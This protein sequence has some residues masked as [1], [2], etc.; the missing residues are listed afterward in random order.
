[1]RILPREEKFFHFFLH[2]V[3]IIT[4]ASD[5]LLEGSRAGNTKLTV[6]AQK[7]VALEQRGD[8]VI[9]EIYEKLNQTFI[10]PIDPEDI[11][12]VGSRLDDVLDGIE[13][14]AHRMTAYRLEPIPGPAIDLCLI[15]Q[16]S[17]HVLKLAFDALSHN[18]NEILQKHCIEI[19]RLEGTA[20]EVFRTAMATLFRTETNAIELLKHKEVF[21]ILEE[22]TDRC[23][24]VA[25]ALQNVAVK[26][27]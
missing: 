20:D 1:M 8:E 7:I 15:V 25:D 14:A 27:S 18:Q 6:A 12:A 11:H 22:I 23:E 26:N 4:E 2:Q 10:T 3:S 19:N 21:E 17:A 9:H 13:E 24:D 5:L 16:S